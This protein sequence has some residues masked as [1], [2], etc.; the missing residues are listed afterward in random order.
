MTDT[1][2]TIPDGTPVKSRE[3]L[4]AEAKVKAKLSIARSKQEDIP[5]D[6][7]SYRSE[8]D[9]EE[10]RMKLVPVAQLD[11]DDSL[12]D[13]YQQ[14][15]ELFNAMQREDHQHDS[16]DRQQT[17]DQLFPSQQRAFV[18]EYYTPIIKELLAKHIE[19]TDK[20]TDFEEAEL[21]FRAKAQAEYAY[22]LKHPDI[23]T[24]LVQGDYHFNQMLSGGHLDIPGY[25]LAER[26]SNGGGIQLVNGA[27]APGQGSFTLIYI[28]V[29]VPNVQSF[30]Q[31]SE[32]LAASQHEYDHQLKRL[33][34][35][36]KAAARKL[37]EIKQSA[38]DA[39][40]AIPSF[41]DLISDSVKRATRK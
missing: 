38:R 33:I 34:E 41:D 6:T 8:W 25:R 30:S 23:I 26:R 7:V 3:L 18:E 39:L 27:L 5:E 29:D 2:T 36:R 15:A 31:S 14:E 10:G 22:R 11:T 37:T 9:P 17:F 16:E 4:K 28:P 24:K 21:T 1:T 35:K 40:A 13:D 32:A 19:A 20:V 12:A